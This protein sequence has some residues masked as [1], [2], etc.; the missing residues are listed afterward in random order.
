MLFYNHIYTL[1]VEEEQFFMLTSQCSSAVATFLISLN[2]KETNNQFL[3]RNFL[4]IEAFIEEYILIKEDY[5]LVSYWWLK[6]KYY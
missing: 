5:K 1:N 4:Y 6:I 3:T 2:N